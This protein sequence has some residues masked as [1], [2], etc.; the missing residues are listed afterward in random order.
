MSKPLGERLVEAGLIT[1]DDVQKALQQQR[2]TG[3]RLGDCLVEVGVLQEASLLR[4][5]AGEL[6]TLFVSTEK[7]AKAK[8]PESVLNRIPVRMAEAQ[9]LLPLTYDAERGV[10]AVV[11]AEPQNA[12]VLKEIALVAETREVYAY[13]GLRSGILAG[14]KR[15]YYGD[16]TA[17]SAPLQPAANVRAD[18]SAIAQAYDASGSSGGTRTAQSAQVPADD[19]RTRRRAGTNTRRGSQLRDT[20]FQSRT[21]ENDYVE[22]LQILVSQLEAGRG[23]LRG[24]SAQLARRAS[25][26]ARRLGMGP[27]EV[28]F[29][30]IAAHL[31][32]LGKGGRH[33]TL[34]T[35]DAG[36]EW[37]AEARRLHRAPIKLFETVHLPVQVN[38][39]LAQL[40]EAFDGSGV[41]H[42]AKGEEITLGARVIAAVDAYLDCTRNS[43]N[44]FGRVLPKD[45]ALA[46]LR[47][48]ANRLFD[49]VVVETMAQLQ[50]GELL[51]QRLRT[52]G[53][54]V[55][56]CTGDDALRSALA[57]ALGG[58]GLVC[59]ELPRLE[60]A[61]DAVLAGDSD[62]LVL[63][64]DLGGPDLMS[65]A[66]F[67]RAQP[68]VAGTPLLVVG[69][70]TDAS[71]RNRMLENGVNAYLPLPLDAAQAGTSVRGFLNDHVQYGAP[72]HPVVG[73]LD[74]LPLRDVL[75]LCGLERK[76]GLLR[77]AAAE[78]EIALHLELGRVVHAR[79][80]NDLGENAL[81]AVLAL[82]QADFRYE[83]DAL[84]LEPPHLDMPLDY[85]ARP[86]GV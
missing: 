28:S 81:R 1:P 74:E 33:H 43:A 15:H 67:L 34:L 32:D 55:T 51:R 12:S 23:E 56:V 9:L 68:E 72:G 8:I 78:Q 49:P 70:P 50:S 21:P 86:G 77:F 63:G 62:L 29:V 30:A 16:P 14:I 82:E 45:E 20:F 80:A 38:A 61:L 85:F 18:L 84:L 11:M 7:L 19:G 54:Q 83:P 48:E 73:S 40:Y 59:Q 31:H 75:S 22:T 44:P 66:K 46:R 3:H 71:I 39:I 57:A 13:I 4:F 17:F 27:R 58:V 64:L 69:E 35:S 24:H 5:L 41:P 42:G 2:I 10:L 26:V 65:L 37:K 6:K 76:S 60:G 25:L 47:K 53:R 52:D 36:P 79:S